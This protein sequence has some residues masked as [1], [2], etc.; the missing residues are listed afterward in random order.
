MSA[1]VQAED[2]DLG[3]E[4]AALRAGR[5][6]IGAVCSFLGIV[7]DRPLTLE[8]YPAMTLKSLQDIE[9]EA[10]ARFDLQACRIVHRFGALQAGEQIVLVAAAVVRNRLVHHR[11]HLQRVREGSG[12]APRA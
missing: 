12:K 6:D 8:H 9:A 11:R 7:R 2:F 5:T 3:V 1:S 10:T 4:V